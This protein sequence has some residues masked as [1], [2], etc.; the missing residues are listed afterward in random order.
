[1]L[2]SAGEDRAKLRTQRD[3]DTKGLES[4]TFFKDTKVGMCKILFRMIRMI[5]P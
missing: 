1:M 2:F 3:K 5:T 4:K